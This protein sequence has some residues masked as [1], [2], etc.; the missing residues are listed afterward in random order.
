[1]KTTIM[2]MIVKRISDKRQFVDIN[3]SATITDC[4]SWDS[5]SVVMDINWLKSRVSDVIRDT[6]LPEEKLS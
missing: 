6:I 3:I 1:M 5:T 2:G 4:K